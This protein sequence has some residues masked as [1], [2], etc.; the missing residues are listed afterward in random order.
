MLVHGLGA[1]SR[2]WERLAEANCGYAATAPDLLGFGR[3]PNRPTPATTW[4]ATSRLWPHCFHPGRGRRAFHGRHPRRGPSRS[5]ARSAA[6]RG[7]GRCRRGH[8]AGGQQPGPAPTGSRSRAGRRPSRCDSGPLR[9]IVSRPD[10]RASARSRG[11]LMIEVAQVAAAVRFADHAETV[12]HNHRTIPAIHLPQTA[13]RG[14]V[15]VRD[16]SDPPL[17]ASSAPTGP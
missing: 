6:A 13:G 11:S 4:P 1:S 10:A 17:G 5:G 2:Y 7:G 14:S 8:P 9:S 15:V 3:S 12:A 16:V